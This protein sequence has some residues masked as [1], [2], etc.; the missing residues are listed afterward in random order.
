MKYRKKTNKLTV[1]ENLLKINNILPILRDIFGIIKI[2]FKFIQEKYKKLNKL[3][4]DKSR[5]IS[6]NNLSI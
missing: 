1:D 2:L 3:V 6:F 5:E 4:Y